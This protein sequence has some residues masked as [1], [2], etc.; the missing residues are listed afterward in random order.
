M[1]SIRIRIIVLSVII[2]LATL[3]VLS[4]SIYE[5]STLVIQYAEKIIFQH[6]TFGVMLFIF[7]ALLSSMLAFY[8][9]A[10]L[11]P[12]GIQTW[13]YA[14]C[15]IFLWLGWL[16]GGI[17]SYCIGRYLGRS[18]VSRI[19]GEKRVNHFESQ[20]HQ[21]IT[22]WH[23]LLFQAALPSEVPGYILGTLQFRFR[24]YVAALAITEFPYA[25]GTVYLGQSFL[26]R[27][28]LNIIIIGFGAVLVGTYLYYLYQ[29]NFHLTIKV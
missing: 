25:I 9:S 22:F 18:V 8:S 10:I 15:F 1:Q 20:I 29:R 6:P 21:N 26:N 3:I 24:L 5:T 11:V 12:I 17:L 23:I 16:L 2:I 27:S 14:N 7:L 13:G 4:D 19:L 28:E